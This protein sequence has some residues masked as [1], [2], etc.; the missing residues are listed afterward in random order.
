MAGPKRP[1]PPTGKP[2][3]PPLPDTKPDLVALAIRRG[4]PS[5]EAWDMTVAELR[6]RLETT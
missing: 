2:T 1:T 5:Y 3:P 6:N 4:V